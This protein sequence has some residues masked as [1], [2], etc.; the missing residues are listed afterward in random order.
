M[1]RRILL[2]TVLAL[3]SS[4]SIATAGS[5]PKETQPADRSGT[6]L[7]AGEKLAVASD[8]QTGSPSPRA[9][10][11]AAD[12]WKFRL[13][14]Y[15]WLPAVKGSVT[16][17]GMKQPI[18][19]SLSDLFRL[20]DE[21][22]VVV[23][24]QFEARHGRW[25]VWLDVQYIKMHDRLRQSV[26]KQVGLAMVTADVTVNVDMRMLLTE[27]G[28][29]YEL[30][31][32]PLGQ[33]PAP[34]LRFDVR[35][36]G[37]YVYMKGE[38]GIAAQVGVQ[39]GPGDVRSPIGGFGRDSGGSRSW[40]EPLLGV[41]V[42][43]D[44]NERLK[45]MARGDIGGFGIG[46]DLTWQVVAGVEYKLCDWASVFAGYRL[47]DIDFTEGHGQS[48]FAFDVQMRGP[49]LAMIFCF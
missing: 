9:P 14:P 24:F 15:A 23:P 33:G 29:D 38:A 6:W 30:F 4:Q 47:L 2:L 49:Y 21:L 22:D 11:P 10:S 25:K 12:R 42:T 39:I 17:L 45:L 37:R 3:A 13:I 34:M 5:K 28:V 32:L 41:G 8:R 40:L 48:K 19:L 18:R 27:F 46:S 44:V 16:V 26:T 35:A 43:L 7:A 31:T 36:G 20:V 1:R